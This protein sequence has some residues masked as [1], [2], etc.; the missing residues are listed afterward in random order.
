VTVVSA[1]QQVTGEFDRV[2]GDRGDAGSRGQPMDEV[3]FDRVK[4]DRGDAGSR[5][6][7]M[8]EPEFD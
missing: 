8:D 4:G 6:Q 5:G 2:K 3:E 1:P 7:P